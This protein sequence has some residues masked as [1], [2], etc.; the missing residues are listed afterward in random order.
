MD[1]LVVINRHSKMVK[2]VMGLHHGNL[3]VVDFIIEFHHGSPKEGEAS[4]EVSSHRLPFPCQ[5]VTG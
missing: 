1:V 5:Q 2:L 4:I 3:K